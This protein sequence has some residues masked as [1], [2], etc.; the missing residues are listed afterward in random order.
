MILKNKLS[1]TEPYGCCII[2]Y[3]KNDNATPEL[4]LDD[5]EYNGLK[6]WQYP[7]LYCFTS[8]AVL[9]ANLAKVKKGDVVADFG[10]GSGIIAVL[11]AAKTNAARIYALEKQKIMCELASKNVKYNNLED[12]IE[13]VGGDIA[14]AAKLLGKESVNVVVCNPP[15]FKK[16][17]GAER[18]REEIALSR[19]ESS[20]DLK[21]IIKSASDVLKWGGALY[22]VH[23]VD[24]MAE[25]IGYMQACALEVKRV[26]LV[27]PKADKSADVFIA[28]ARKHGSTGMKLDEL[29]VYEA[30]GSMT[31]RAKKLYSKE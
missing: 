13:V 22:I 5:L 2:L 18:E 26:T 11:I 4:R 24:R 1:L 30:D 29:V 16:G 31:A 12:K 23:K 21:G 7:S 15:Y 28:E 20:C 27:Y 3:M 10:T 25:A 17:S 9:L 19:H 6:L 8:D 14:D